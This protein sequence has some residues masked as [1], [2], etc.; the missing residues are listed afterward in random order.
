[1]TGKQY[2]LNKMI[3]LLQNCFTIQRYNIVILYNYEIIK[4]ITLKW[5][6]PGGS[7]GKE[8]VCNAEDE[9]WVLSLKGE[10]PLEKEQQATPVFVL[11][12]SQG[13]SSLAG[14][15]PWGHKE[16]DTTKKLNNNNYFKTA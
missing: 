3:I 2:L 4:V 10:D 13:Q 1:M 14:Y 6:F 15:S 11:G 9:I 16:L 8:S 5:D 7:A 12:K